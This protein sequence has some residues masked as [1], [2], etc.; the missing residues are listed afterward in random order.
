[1]NER[2][3]APG[4]G[5]PLR[6]LLVDD[7]TLFRQGLRSALVADGV[8]VVGEAP[9]GEAGARLAGELRPDVVVVDLHMPIL[10]GIGAV[11]RISALRPAPRIL[12]L[13]VSDDEDDVVGALMAG[14]SGYVLKSAAMQDVVQAVR[15]VRDGDSVISPKVA[16]RLVDR[17][18]SGE[19]APAPAPGAGSLTPREL[20]ILRL[21]A[22]GRENHEIAEALVISPSTA[23]NHVASVLEK[24]GLDNRVQA[25]VYAVRAGLV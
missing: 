25:A 4:T 23:K 22:L 13:S 19:V 3:L 17:L 2:P 7:H 9:N 24:L 6:A 12:V 1:M 16:G 14:A 5:A 10:D 20:E 8:E 11:E 18:R 21:V 15:A